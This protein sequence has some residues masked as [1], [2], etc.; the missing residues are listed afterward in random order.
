MNKCLPITKNMHISSEIPGCCQ[1]G[2]V[3]PTS[4]PSAVCVSL[5][6]GIK[7]RV[8]VPSSSQSVGSFNLCHFQ[9]LNVWNPAPRGIGSID[10]FGGCQLAVLIG[11]LKGN[12]EESSEKQ[13]GFVSHSRSAQRRQTQLWQ[14]IRLIRCACLCACVSLDILI[15]LQ[16]NFFLNWWDRRAAAPAQG[17]GQDVS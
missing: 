14:C 9:R 8:F 12:N 1:R 3:F 6:V 7:L 17:P 2:A 11:I 15:K 13:S 10:W 5:C 4:S 16:L